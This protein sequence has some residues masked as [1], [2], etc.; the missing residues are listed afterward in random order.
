MQYQRPNEQADEL[1]DLAWEASAPAARAQFARKALMIDADAIDAYVVL[2]LS[3]DALGEQIALLREAV[4]IGKRF[5][6]E[7]IK[8]PSQHYFWLDIETRPFMRAAQNLAL[9]LWQ[10][11]ERE[12]AVEVADFLLELNPND[13]QGI[14]YLA[15]AWHPLLGNW[16]RVDRLLKRYHQEES[17]EYLY[18]A[19]LN[20]FRRGNDA[21][22]ML[23]RAIDI[24]PHVPDLLL[25]RA[26][27]PPDRGADYVEF[28]SAD[29]AA[30][31]ARVNL[32]A[33]SNV[34]GALD[35]LQSRRHDT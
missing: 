28:G 14:R 2:A 18:A 12:E 9:A 30:S 21:L 16:T 7:P 4:R 29:E 26:P 22:P 31:Y 17:T 27:L 19:T 25:G 20:A 11:G 34:P 13:N 3:T 33:W 8:R 35:W 5:W 23:Q 24:N 15:L 10:R 1:I 6:A 32:E